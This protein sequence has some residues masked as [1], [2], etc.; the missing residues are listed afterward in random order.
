MP[1]G[2][3]EWSSPNV[4]PLPRHLSARNLQDPGQQTVFRPKD[5][6]KCPILQNMNVKFCVNPDHLSSRSPDIP[7]SS[8]A[9]SCHGPARVDRIS[10]AGTD[11]L[12]KNNLCMHHAGRTSLER[13]GFLSMYKENGT[14][15]ERLQTKIRVPCLNDCLLFPK[16]VRHRA[17]CCRA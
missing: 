13:H 11:M 15:Q 7:A 3:T 8:E 4:C 12:H 17:A 9:F 14:R 1:A 5:G 16:P 2:R 10:V 6:Q